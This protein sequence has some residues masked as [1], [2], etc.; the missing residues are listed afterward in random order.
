MSTRHRT[1][2]EVSREALLWNFRQF[3]RFFKGA[4][5]ICPIVKSNAYGHDSTWVSQTLPKSQ[6]WG[7]G[8]AYDTEV[9]EIQRFAKGKPIIVLS[10]WQ[11][12]NLPKLIR[13]GVRLVVWDR[14]AA[15]AINSAA[16]RVHRHAFVHVKIDT[17]TTR[18]GTRPEALNDLW[19]TLQRSTNLTI[20][21]VFSH[22]ANSENENLRF[23]EYQQN[24]FQQLAPMF[25]APLQHLACTAASIRLPLRGTNL[26]RLGIGLYGLWP[27]AAT[28]L[29]NHGVTPKPV[30]TWKTRMVQM[31]RVPAGTT[32]GYDRT[33]RVRTPTTIGVLPVG[34]AD[35][36]DRRGSNR[37]LVVIQGRQHPVVGRVGMNLT[38]IDLGPRARVQPGTEITLVGRGVSAD[39]IARS[40]DTIN[41]EVVARID[42]AIPRIEVP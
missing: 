4:A 42:R 2:V 19:R 30:L 26:V 25:S 1:W 20:E 8:V 16:R 15:A 14:E 10:A 13:Q 32:V 35:G 5:Q 38:M 6:I 18:I 17:G 22:Y 12:H 23:A 28:M 40:W 36:Y 39:D 29:D 9:E 33:Y 7:F 37:G 21:G 34:Y 31:K 11:E 24:L 3:Q 27:S 41:Y